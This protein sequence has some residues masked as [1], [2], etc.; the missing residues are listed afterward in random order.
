MWWT[1]S[2]E[3][4]FWNFE[5]PKRCVAHHQLYTVAVQHRKINPRIRENQI[6]LPLN[7]CILFENIIQTWLLYDQAFKEAIKPEIQHC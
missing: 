3:F 2:N 7:T 5:A 6:I 4:Q 1:S